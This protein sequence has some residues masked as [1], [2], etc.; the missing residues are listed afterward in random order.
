MSAPAAAS[1]GQPAPSIAA[2]TAAKDPP[3]GEGQEQ[4]AGTLDDMQKILKTRGIKMDKAFLRDQF[5]KNGEDAILSA[6]REALFEYFLYQKMDPESVAKA[7]PEV[8]QQLA[9]A[10]S[11]GKNYKDAVDSLGLKESPTKGGASGIASI[12]TPKS[13]DS[14][15]VAAR[16]G[17]ALLTQNQ[18]RQVAGGGGGGGPAVT[19]NVNGPGGQQLADMMQNAATNVVRD[20]MQKQKQR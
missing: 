18:L 20:W 17:E 12:P 4:M 11:G 16:P 15:F 1:A 8:G 13:P 10:L 3:T 2:A 14:V 9:D 19:V 6:T 7:G 5:W